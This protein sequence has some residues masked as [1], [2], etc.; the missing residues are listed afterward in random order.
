MVHVHTTQLHKHT[1]SRGDDL[2]V[3]RPWLLLGWW[4]DTSAQTMEWPAQQAHARSMGGACLVRC[5]VPERSVA[6]FD[7]YE[8]VLQHVVWGTAVVQREC[9]AAR[10]E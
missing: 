6:T 9:I 1:L 2:C 5:Q 3:I 10:Q 8:G 4:V 7:T